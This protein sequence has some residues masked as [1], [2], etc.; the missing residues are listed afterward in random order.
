MRNILI[1]LSTMTL[2]SG[3]LGGLSGTNYLKNISTSDLATTAG[4]VIGAGAGSAVGLPL[5]GTIFT[6]VTGAGAGA[7]LVGEPESTLK[8]ELDA[9][10]EDE[11]AEAFKYASRWDAIEDIFMYIVAAG[12]AMMIIPMVL[13]YLIPRRRE[14]HLERMLFDDPYYEAC[15]DGVGIKKCEKKPKHKEEYTNGRI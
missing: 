7:A 12:A 8:D 14:K 11:R 13:G 1:L 2:L 10:P 4:A 15:E 6:T 9:L 5:G 3:C